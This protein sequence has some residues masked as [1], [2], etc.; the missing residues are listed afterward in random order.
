MTPCWRH[1]SHRDLRYLS[2]LVAESFGI[3]QGMLFWKNGS[4]AVREARRVFCLY[5]RVVEQVPY[6]AAAR[7]LRVHHESARM[8][9]RNLAAREPF[10]Y[11][12][13]FDRLKTTFHK[14]LE[15]PNAHERKTESQMDFRSNERPATPAKAVEGLP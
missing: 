14:H 6:S 1:L 8:L 5:L 15:T 4:P 2:F 7:F 13:L 9:L 12:E 3:R 11:T 10:P